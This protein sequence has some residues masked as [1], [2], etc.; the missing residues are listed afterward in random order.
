MS[1]I[2]TPGW[3]PYRAWGN[4]DFPPGMLAAHDAILATDFTVYAGGH[5]Y[6]CGTRADVERSREL[7]IDLITTTKRYMGEVSYG[8]AAA[9]VE[10][11]NVWAAQA[12]WIDRIGDA[13][14]AE[15]VGRW[16][17]RVA[18]MDAFT[19]DNVG[20]M[21]VSLAADGPVNFP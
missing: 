13:V 8:K 18:G 12:L 20:C 7:L 2:L 17:D 19:K 14:M 3:A 4:A 16:A 15:L 5:G 21:A 10:Q 6:R 11:D 9:E 1:D